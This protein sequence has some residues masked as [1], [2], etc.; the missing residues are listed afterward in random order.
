MTKTITGEIPLIC[1]SWKVGSFILGQSTACDAGILTAEGM[2][3][4]SCPT[5]SDS[6]TTIVKVFEFIN[7]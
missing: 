7:K 1:A 3:T 5:T 2:T 4:K 6:L